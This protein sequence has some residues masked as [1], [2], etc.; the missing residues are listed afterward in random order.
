[1]RRSTEP[2]TETNYTLL[3]Q[4]LVSESSGAGDWWKKEMK[5]GS[6]SQGWVFSALVCCSASR[7]KCCFISLHFLCLCSRYTLSYSCLW[8][9]L[10]WKMKAAGDGKQHHYLVAVIVMTY[11]L[12]IRW[13]FVCV[14]IQTVS[15][16]YRQSHFRTKPKCFSERRFGPQLPHYAFKKCRDQLELQPQIK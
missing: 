9:W 5:Y 14:L 8:I 12:I 1:M 16:R 2:R 13:L 6:K 4:C 11:S 7:A 10:K 15:L 3:T